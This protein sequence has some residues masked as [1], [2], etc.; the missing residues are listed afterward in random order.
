MNNKAI[1]VNLRYSKIMIKFLKKKTKSYKKMIKL[2]LKF[3]KYAKL[4]MIQ[5]LSFCFQI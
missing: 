3:R 5:I 1:K 2:K 4:E